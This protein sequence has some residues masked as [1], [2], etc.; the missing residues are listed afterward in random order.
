MLDAMVDFTGGVSS[1]VD[2][3]GQHNSLEIIP[4]D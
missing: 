1:L 3:K 2:L 4:L